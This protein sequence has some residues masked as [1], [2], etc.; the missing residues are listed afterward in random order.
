MDA[1]SADDVSAA[2]RIRG[3]LIGGA[4]GDAWGSAFEHRDTAASAVERAWAY[5]DDTQFTLATCEAILEAGAVQTARVAE[6]FVRWYRERRFTGVGASS[7]KALRDL[8]AGAHWALCG[9]R[10]S[11]AA[12]NGAAMRIAP[13]AFLLDPDD[14][15]DRRLIREISR[16]THHHDEA[17]VGALAVLYA[18]RSSFDGSSGLRLPVVAE[19]LP[20]SQVR[21][22]LFRFAALGNVRVED[23]AR[24]HGHSGF[25]AE[26]VPLALFAATRGAQLG[27]AGM[28]EEVMRAGGDTDTIGSMSGQL[29]GAANGRAAVP[30]TLT[31]HLPVWGKLGVIEAFAQWAAPRVEANLSKRFHERNSRQ[32]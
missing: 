17:Y 31:A 26:S 15:G 30:E 12:G 10:G 4:I 23:A 27:F 21:D 3:C 6:V 7:L 19:Q 13:L 25:V 24:A 28:M 11:R 1:T 5:T 2:D 9:A 32:G 8:D 29:W 16:I 20:D 18:I 14:S 22:Q